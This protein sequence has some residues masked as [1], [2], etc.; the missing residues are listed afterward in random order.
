MD[1]NNPNAPNLT[2][3]TTTAQ[4]SV[5]TTTSSCSVIAITAADN[6]READ[7]FKET[8]NHISSLK[9]QYRTKAVINKRIYDD[10]M[11]ALKLEK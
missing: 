6:V 10:I 5:I 1:D 7:F 4:C 2:I 8:D 9:E 3:I 11:V